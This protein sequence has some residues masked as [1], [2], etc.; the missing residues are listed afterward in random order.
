[1][2]TRGQVDEA[3]AELVE[4][5]AFAFLDVAGGISAG[6]GAIKETV[7]FEKQAAAAAKESR[8]AGREVDPVPTRMG[9]PTGRGTP[10]VECPIICP[11]VS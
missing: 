1:L 10:L 8:R 2:V 11:P 6:H 4:K 3:R 7:E 5:A 9:G